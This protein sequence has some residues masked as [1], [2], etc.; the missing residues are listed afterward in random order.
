M[1]AVL[2]GVIFSRTSISMVVV[3][4]GSFSHVTG[5][6]KFFFFL[7]LLYHINFYAICILITMDIHKLHWSTY[8]ILFL[9][10]DVLEA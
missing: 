2:K 9:K 4:G 10:S 1:V 3:L 8:F 6:Q 7:D 5:L